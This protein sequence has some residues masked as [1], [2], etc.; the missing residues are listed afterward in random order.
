[1]ARPDPG[2]RPMDELGVQVAAA[3]GH[4]GLE[5]GDRRVT[6]F[7][8]RADRSPGGVTRA[9]WGSRATRMGQQCRVVFVERP[10]PRGF[11]PLHHGPFSLVGPSGATS[12]EVVVAIALCTFDVN[13]PFAR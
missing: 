10:N 9:P 11:T 5:H 6:A 4:A 12:K 1:M 2:L 3:V 13:S 8:Q 7:S